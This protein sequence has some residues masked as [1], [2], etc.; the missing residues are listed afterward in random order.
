MP[1]DLNALLAANDE[2]AERLSWIFD[3][4]LELEAHQSDWF[5]IDGF[6]THRHIGREGAGGVFVQLPDQRILYI[7][8]EGQAGI[9]ASDF[10]AF[11]QLIVTHPYWQDLL[12]FS[13][14]G[15]L[16]EMRRA[17][18]AL[19]AMT[20]DE[21]E[22][23]EEAREYV[24]SELTLKEPVD[25]IAALH[26]AVSTSNVIVRSSFDGNPAQSLFNTFTADSSPSLRPHLE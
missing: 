1:V 15:K 10:N 13:G 11:M 21:E 24:K 18:I 16:A 17:A 22:D 26:R 5:T 25:A 8:S 2:V 6:E 12:K 3:F 9:I 4:R 23:L 7:S 20:A 19:K 14:G